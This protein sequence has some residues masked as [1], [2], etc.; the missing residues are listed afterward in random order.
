MN[1]RS[2]LMTTTAAGAD[3]AGGS[4]ATP[5]FGL[6]ISEAEAARLVDVSTRHLQRLRVEGGGPPY[7]QLGARRIGYRLADLESWIAGRRVASTSAVTVGR[8]A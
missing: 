7:I 3:A 4:R 8:R 5:P 6:V 1:T 2:G